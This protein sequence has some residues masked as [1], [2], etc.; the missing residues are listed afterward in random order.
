VT[1]IWETDPNGDWLTL[2]PTAYLAEAELH[3]LVRDA[4][5]VLPLAGTPHLT[6]LGREVRL[7][8]ATPTCWL[9]NRPDGW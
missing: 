5:Q 3:D 9:S 1:A 6:V 4:P 2:A 7:G 8:M